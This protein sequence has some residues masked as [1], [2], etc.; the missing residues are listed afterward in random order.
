MADVDPL[1]APPA[2]K[3]K[4][5]PPCVVPGCKNPLLSSGQ[6]AFV[7]WDIIRMKLANDHPEYLQPG[8]RPCHCKKADCL[9]WVDKKEGPKEPGRP[10]LHGKKRKDNEGSASVENFN[11]SN[12]PPV[13]TEA[14]EIWG[15]RYAPLCFPRVRAPIHP[16]PRAPARAAPHASLR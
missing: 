9:R 8:L 4:R 1:D 7:P 16:S 10:A 13:L 14:T 5:G 15:T 12:H 6:W 2:D 3:D 11:D